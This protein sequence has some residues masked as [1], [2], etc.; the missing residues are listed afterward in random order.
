M[1]LAWRPGALLILGALVPDPAALVSPAY[2]LGRKPGLAFEQASA[3]APIGE[4]RELAA[5]RYARCRRA[6]SVA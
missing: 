1:F 5:R 4:P 2:V 6:S 3:A